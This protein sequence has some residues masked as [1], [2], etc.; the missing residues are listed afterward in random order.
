MLAKNKILEKTGKKDQKSDDFMTGR[1]GASDSYKALTQYS[2]AVYS[3]ASICM[4]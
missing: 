3:S 1:E 4:K 2:Y